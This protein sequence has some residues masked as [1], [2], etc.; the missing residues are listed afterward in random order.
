MSGLKLARLPDRV[1]VKLTIAVSPELNRALNDYASAYERAY[2]QSEAAV[3]LIPA[4]LAAFLSSDR[5][6]T[7]MRRLSIASD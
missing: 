2:G 4:M 1:P 7:R 3:D 6:F 5:E